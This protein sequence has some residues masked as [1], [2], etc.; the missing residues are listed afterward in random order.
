MLVLE[1]LCFVGVQNL[2]IFYMQ[3]TPLVE[4]QFDLISLIGLIIVYL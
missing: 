1:R 4:M 3:G 2:R